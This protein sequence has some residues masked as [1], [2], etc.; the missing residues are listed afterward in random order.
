MTSISTTTTNVLAS[1]YN[2]LAEEKTMPEEKQQNTLVESKYLQP[3]QVDISESG[4]KKLSES[5]TE[6][7][8][9]LAENANQV[10]TK[11]EVD[12]TN[13]ANESDIDKEISKLSMEIL[14]LTVQIEMLKA[15]E[16]AESV[17]EKQSLETELAIKKGTL[18]AAIERKLQMA[19]LT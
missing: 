5:E 11:E 14:E 10:M 18:E 16:D 2:N 4:Q 15:K 13:K 8:K 7:Q 9:S 1:T 17:K 6:D 3:D 12:A 19:A